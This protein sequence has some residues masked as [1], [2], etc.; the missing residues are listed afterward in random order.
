MSVPWNT[1]QQGKG[2]SHGHAQLGSRMHIMN[3]KSPSEGVHP[4]G[5]PFYDALEVTRLQMEKR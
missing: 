1:S 4:I 3:G 5:V 2:A